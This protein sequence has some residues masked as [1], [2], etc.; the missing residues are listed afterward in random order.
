MDRFDDSPEAPRK[1]LTEYLEVPLRRPR[2]VLVPF[3][4]ITAAALAASFLVAKKYR[5][6]TFI[7]VE[8]EKVPDAVLPRMAVSERAERRMQTIKQ[9]ILSRTRLEQVSRR[10][11]PTRTSQT[12]RP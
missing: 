4:L 8:S 3:I 12:A 10:R 6:S 1:A 9:E 5:S 2:L 7:L 11:N